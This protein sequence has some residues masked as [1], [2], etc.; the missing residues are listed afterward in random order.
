MRN[1]LLYLRFAMQYAVQN[2]TLRHMRY[3]GKWHRDM[4]SGDNTLNRAQP[5][6]TYDAQQFLAEICKPDMRIFEWGSGGSTLFFASRCAQVVTI[7][8]DAP[9]VGFVREKI[10]QCGIKNVDL[11]GVAGEKTDGSLPLN[12]ENADDFASKDPKSA[13]LSFEKYVKTI[14]DFPPEYFDMVV[15]DGRARNS[16][17][18]RAIPHI[19]QGGFLAVDNADRKYYLAPFPQLNNPQMWE[20]TEFEGPVFFQHAFSKTSFFRKR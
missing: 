18:K 12:P 20:K 9:W 13:G 14:D 7:E 2:S 1:L 16:C 15:V 11:R 17:I 3:L 6:M 19:R 4:Q 10:R 8:H 5:W